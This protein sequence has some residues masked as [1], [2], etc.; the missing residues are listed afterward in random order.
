M[1]VSGWMRPIVV[2]SEAFMYNRF[3]R[4]ACLLQEQHVWQILTFSDI[5]KRN[6]LHLVVKLNIY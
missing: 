1:Y 5:S 2:C 4:A 6:K 3:T